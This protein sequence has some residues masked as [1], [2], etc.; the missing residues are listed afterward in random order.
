MA[1]A[2]KKSSAKK[3]AA[4]DDEG[5][6]E[7]LLNEAVENVPEEPELNAGEYRFRVRSFSV[8]AKRGRLMMALA[9]LEGVNGSE[10]DGDPA[11][12][13]PVFQNFDPTRAGDMRQLS[14]IAAAAGVD[15][16]LSRKEVIDK[17]ALVGVELVGAVVLSENKENP[18]RPYRNVRGLKFP[19]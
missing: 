4:M 13:R 8:N 5:S 1:T 10:I 3:A 6:F 17:K 18:D 14:E 12:Y 15:T 9:P 19:E 11:T 7:D 2:K 16:S